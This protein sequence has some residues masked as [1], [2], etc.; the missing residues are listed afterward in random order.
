[1]GS[2][3]F[4]SCLRLGI[5][6]FIAHLSLGQEK[7]FTA[8]TLEAYLQQA[9]KA[10]PSLKAFEAHYDAATQRIPQVS[11]LPDPTF[12]ITHFVESIQTRTGPQENAFVLSQRIPWFGKLG[13]REA[14]ASAEAEALWFA[15]QN[16]Q[17]TLARAVSLMYYE[18][19]YTGHAINLTRENLAL[20]EKLEPITEEKV[21]VGGDLNT[22]LRLKV[23]IGKIADQLQSLEQKRVAQSAQLN[24]LLALSTDSS[25][26]WPTWQAPPIEELDARSLAIAIEANNP[27]LEMLQR[28]IASAEAR[29]EIA[30]LE[31]YPD[32]TLGLNYIQVGDPV[33]N[34]TTPDAGQDP[35]GFTVAVNIPIWFNKY[36]AGRAE[37]LASKR[38]TENEYQSRLNQ[39]K[40]DLSASL[41]R[42]NDA[43]RRL[44]LY[45]EELLQLAEQ[46][47][48]IT[49]SSYESGRTGI[50]EVIDSER[51]LLELQ[52]LYWRAAADAWQQR[53]VIQ[54]LA[55]QPL[56][57][58]LNPV[59]EE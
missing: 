30:R 52:T 35:W 39:L 45:G 54:T 49:R 8:T 22:L 50:L 23:E 20:L 33:V 58:T 4:I 47:A 59:S 6:L 40:S 24:E 3:R 36:D 32:I 31:N 5:C 29:K 26:P 17:L 11:A 42:L 48:E 16:R 38:A 57:G 12:Q 25:L 9:Q 55:N 21:K 34:P 7:A 44:K 53:I 1:M 51:S 28:K 19:G 18:Y 41:A 27:E 10:N 46:A 15:Y 37:A 13:S 14:A 2:F 56:L 43:N